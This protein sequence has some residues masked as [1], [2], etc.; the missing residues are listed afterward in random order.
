MF[1]LIY[2]STGNNLGYSSSCNRLQRRTI[3]DYFMLQ[4]IV[5]FIV[6]VYD[7]G[8]DDLLKL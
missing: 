5:V 8:N 7:V 3:I 4:E 2:Q 1:V 6:K